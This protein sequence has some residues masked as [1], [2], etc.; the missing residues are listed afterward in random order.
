MFGWSCEARE[1]VVEIKSKAV[2]SI[3]YEVLHDVDLVEESLR[4][5]HL[6]LR[7]DLD[8]SLCAAIF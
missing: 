7:D 5:F 3:A 1:G 2:T 6:A 8:C 4:V